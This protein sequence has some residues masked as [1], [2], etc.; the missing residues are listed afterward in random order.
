MIREKAA[1]ITRG[2][3]FMKNKRW[4]RRH[5]LRLGLSTLAGGWML[6]RMLPRH[7]LAAPGRHLCR[8]TTAD[9]P[10]E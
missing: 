2:S 7:A 6:P 5:V 1:C 4:N 9:G 10:N 3:S 8:P